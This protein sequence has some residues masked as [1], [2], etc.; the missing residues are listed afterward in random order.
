MLAFAIPA[1]YVVFGADGPFNVSEICD[2][3]Y[4]LHGPLQTAK[5]FVATVLFT[6]QLN[7][8]I[9]VLFR[10][11]MRQPMEVFKWFRAA[12][13]PSRLDNLLVFGTSHSS[14]SV[15]I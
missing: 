2:T 13:S 4:L 6:K 1:W 11:Q 8:Q 3:G 14:F 5:A 7:W 10:V 9:M 15:N 12:G